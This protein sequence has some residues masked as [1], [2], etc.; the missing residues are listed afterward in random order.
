[1]AL[2]GFM[3]DYHENALR[4]L[5]EVQNNIQSQAC[6][7][8]GK[9]RDEVIPVARISSVMKNSPKSSLDAISGP[10]EARPLKPAGPPPPAAP[11]PA[12]SCK[13]K[14]WHC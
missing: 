1:M 2:V 8:Q 6:E 7:A 13:G 10:T 9:P 12:A 11:K 14:Y 3:K 5:E 4:V